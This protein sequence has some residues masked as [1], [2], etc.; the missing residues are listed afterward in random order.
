MKKK[1]DLKTL[2]VTSFLTMPEKIKGGALHSNPYLS[3]CV[4][5][6]EICI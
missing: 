6:S 3:I 2:E 4:D 1:I 5:C